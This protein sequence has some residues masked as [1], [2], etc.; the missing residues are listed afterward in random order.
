MQHE[1]GVLADQ[2]LGNRL[3]AINQG[4][5]KARQALKKLEEPALLPPVSLIPLLSGINEEWEDSGKRER[6]W[7]LDPE[8]ITEQVR[9]LQAE[10]LIE[11]ALLATQSQR[12]RE[13]TAA[14]DDLAEAL[15][16][17]AAVHADGAISVQFG[18]SGNTPLEPHEVATLMVSRPSS[19]R[20][21][22]GAAR[23]CSRG[24]FVRS[25]RR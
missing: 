7:A 13:A 17:R 23:R 12:D 1:Y 8:L 2:Q 14:L 16:L 9:E 25:S 20:A 6:S 5:K 4:L 18:I 19:C 21:R 22:P 10:M 11:T 3:T 15:G 24:R